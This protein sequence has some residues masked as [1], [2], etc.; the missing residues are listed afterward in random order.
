MLCFYYVSSYYLT[1]TKQFSDVRNTKLIVLLTYVD[2]LAK[3]MLSIAIAIFD[4]DEEIKEQLF[5]I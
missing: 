3:S 2:Y 1:L 5:K 4:C